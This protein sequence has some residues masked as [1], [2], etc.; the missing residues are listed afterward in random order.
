MDRLLTV[1]GT[2]HSSA[3]PDTV[4]IGGELEGLRSTYGEAVEA[5]ADVVESLKRSVEA[6]GFDP[7]IVRTRSL[8]VDSSYKYVNG[9]SIFEGYRYSH[10][11]GI[12]I[13]RCE[14]KLDLLLRALISDLNAPEFRISYL[15]A[16]QTEARNEARRLA[17]EDARRK[18]EALAEAA[19]VGIG[20]IVS[21]TYGEGYGSGETGGRLMI[22]GSHGGMGSSISPEDVEFTEEV[23]VQWEIV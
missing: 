5:A 7:T 17:V 23:I 9:E 18:A 16:D 6:V 2:G 12:S 19:G 4:R 3:E 10:R 15:L 11:I 13:P 14:E 22:L 8:S 20:T 21:L 1:K